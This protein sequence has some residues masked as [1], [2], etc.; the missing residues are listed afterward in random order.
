LV[1]FFGRRAIRPLSLAK[2]NEEKQWTDEG[3]NSAG[4]WRGIM[5]R[6][7][8]AQI[9]PLSRILRIIKRGMLF[10][11]DRQGTGS[12]CNQGR[13]KAWHDAAPLAC[14]SREMDG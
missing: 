9:L 5:P 12:A 4:K 14:E 6:L 2:Q 11:L 8:S 7:R 3:Q 10:P 1:F 13:F